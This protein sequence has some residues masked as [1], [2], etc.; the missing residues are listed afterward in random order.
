MIGFIT[1]AIFNDSLEPLFAVALLIVCASPGGSYSNWWC[2]LINADLALSVAMTTVSTIV[3]AVVLPL[4][5]LLYIEFGY[6]KLD[7]DNA[8]DVVDKLPYAVIGYTLANVISAV[9]IGLYLGHKYPSKMKTINAVGTAAGFLSIILGVFVSSTSCADPWAQDPILYFAVLCPV[10][11]GI[12]LALG[13]AT[14]AGLPKP[15]R[16]AVSIE[17]AYQN[18]GIALAVAISLGAEGR[19]AAIVPVMYGGYEGTHMLVASPRSWL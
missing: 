7:P 15:Q 9:T 13:L 16:V 19:A 12:S 3:S 1:V 10:L 5:I 2:N 11:A 4:N 8:Q 6:K 18:T 14:L 17:T